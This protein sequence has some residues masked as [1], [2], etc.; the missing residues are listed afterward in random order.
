MP[1]PYLHGYY[2]QDAGAP[3]T[4]ISAQSPTL[5]GAQG[6]MI[7]TAGDLNRFIT[8]LFSGRLLPPAE[9]NDMF[10]IPAAAS[11]TICYGMG[12]LAYTL[13]NGVTL[14]GHTGETPGYASGVFATRDLARTLA[15]IT[16]PI[17]PASGSQVLAME[18]RIAQA[19]YNPP[20]TGS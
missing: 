12:L 17:G 18:L 6:A 7:S 15:Y 19:A 1:R 4:D 3:P 13:P 16:T 8:A 20:F 10:T 9:L 11:G 14:W 5:F 2:Q